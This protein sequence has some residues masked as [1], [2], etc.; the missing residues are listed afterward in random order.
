MGVEFSACALSQ[1]PYEFVLPALKR[2]L[3]VKL[4]HF[5]SSKL[6]SRKNNTEEIVA[7]DKGE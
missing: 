5:T 1:V 4:L 7:L 2:Q 3:L 6:Q